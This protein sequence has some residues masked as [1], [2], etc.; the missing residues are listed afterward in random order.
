MSFE[1]PTQLDQPKNSLK[2]IDACETGGLKSRLIG[3]RVVSWMVRH[4]NLVIIGAFALLTSAFVLDDR[5]DN[6]IMPKTDNPKID[7]EYKNLTPDSVKL[8]C[9]ATYD[10]WAGVGSEASLLYKTKNFGLPYADNYQLVQ[11]L[12]TNPKLKKLDREV[13]EIFGLDDNLGVVDK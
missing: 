2:D 6:Q 13:E 1:N 12:N 5:N 10:N 4:P 8:K 7:C 9:S 11:G 3:N